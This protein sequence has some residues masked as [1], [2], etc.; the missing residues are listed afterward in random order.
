MFVYCLN[1]S[2]YLQFRTS[3]LANNTLFL[4][5]LNNKI[6]NKSIQIIIVNQT[7]SYILSFKVW[8]L[9]I[10]DFEYNLRYYKLKLILIIKT[11]LKG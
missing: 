7:A 1:T 8:G 5:I 3:V 10:G 11:F 9:W 4:F 2:K 6:L